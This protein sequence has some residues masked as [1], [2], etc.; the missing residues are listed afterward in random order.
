MRDVITTHTHLLQKLPAPRGIPTYMPQIL[1]ERYLVPGYHEGADAPSRTTSSRS[2]QQPG[3]NSEVLSIDSLA[4]LLFA[5][6]P[7]LWK[8]LKAC[9]GKGYFWFDGFCRC[10]SIYASTMGIYG[11]VEVGGTFRGEV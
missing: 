4:G 2:A 7:V 6:D 9:Y 1:H 5:A 3:D 11:T 8:F 10:A